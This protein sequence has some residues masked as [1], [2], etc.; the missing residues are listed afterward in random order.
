MGR[1]KTGKEKGKEKM[2]KGRKKRGTQIS[3]MII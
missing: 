2:E 3:V 1:N